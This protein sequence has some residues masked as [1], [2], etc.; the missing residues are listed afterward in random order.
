MITA[1]QSALTGWQDSVHHA[2]STGHRSGADET[3]LHLPTGSLLY[4][5]TGFQGF[6]LKYVTIF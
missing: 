1:G 6:T 2:P 3:Q 5:D 4:Q